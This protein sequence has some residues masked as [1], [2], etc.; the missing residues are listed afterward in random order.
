[1]RKQDIKVGD[2]LGHRA[3]KWH[4]PTKVTVIETDV[5]KY[6]ASFERLRKEHPDRK[7]RTWDIYKRGTRVRF[8][9]DV[10]KPV[11][12][13][14]NRELV[15]PWEKIERENLTSAIRRKEGRAR[16]QAED[17]AA[18]ALASLYNEEIAPLLA[19]RL[20]E[21]HQLTAPEY[22]GRF[23]RV[24]PERLVEMLAAALYL[25]DDE[26][27][28]FESAYLKAAEITAARDL[29]IEEVEEEAEHELLTMEP[30]EA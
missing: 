9:T 18:I 15:G 11:R 8:E 12:L 5:V 23:G 10:V 2:V 19:K 13:V 28:A 27:Q 21:K 3:R 16:R 30:V 22:G 25:E 17:E 1:M 26:R 24:T 14:E 4:D 7:P 6:T 20:D 29:R